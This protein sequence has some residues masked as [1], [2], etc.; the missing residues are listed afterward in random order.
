MAVRHQDGQS[1]DEGER[2]VEQVAEVIRNHAARE[3]F[4]RVAGQCGAQRQA[5][6]HEASGQTEHEEQVFAAREN[7]AEQHDHA[8]QHQDQRRRESD[9]VVGVIAHNV[10]WEMTGLR[11]LP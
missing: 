5:A 3:R 6:R 2:D 1:G 7:L 9:D 8:E 11:P 10:H 4:G